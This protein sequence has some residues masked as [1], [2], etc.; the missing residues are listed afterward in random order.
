MHAR[1]DAASLDRATEG[2]EQAV[3]AMVDGMQESGSCTSIILPW[4]M[5][6]TAKVL[7][8]QPEKGARLRGGPRRLQ[9]QQGR[10]QLLAC[11]LQGTHVFHSSVAWLHQQAGDTGSPHSSSLI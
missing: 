1:Q 5:T 6:C 4:G 3:G 10:H 2:P 11:I 9:A 8:L 7:P